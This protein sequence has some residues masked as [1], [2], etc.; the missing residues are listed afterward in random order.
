MRFDTASLQFTLIAL[1]HSTMAIQQAG[2]DAVQAAGEVL[3]RECKKAVGLRDHSLTDL[4]KMDHPYARRHGSIRVHTEAP[5]QVH[6]KPS[7]FNAK[8]RNQTDTLYRATQG[9][10]YLANG[11]PMYEVRFNLNDAPHA[12]FVVGG[13]RVMLPRDPLWITANDPKVRKALMVGIIRRLG[14]E[15]RTKLGVRF[16]TMP[17]TSTRTTRGFGG[18]VGSTGVR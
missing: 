14:K 5:W 3:L 1:D 13:T 4:A 17:A 9:A 11:R 6:R 15:L 7:P 16:G 10:Y 8:H 2:E 12:R 18:H